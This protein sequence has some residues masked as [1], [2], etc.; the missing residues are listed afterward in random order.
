MG[1]LLKEF[2]GPK[3]AHGCAPRF[4]DSVRSCSSTRAAA[5][6]PVNT[7]GRRPVSAY[8]VSSFCQVIAPLYGGAF[9]VPEAQRPRCFNRFGYAD[10]SNSR[11]S[12]LH[13][14][15]NSGR[16]SDIRK[17]AG[18]VAMSARRSSWGREYRAGTFGPGGRRHGRG[19]GVPC[20]SRDR[21]VSN[22]RRAAGRRADGRRGRRRA[23]H[24]AGPLAVIRLGACER[25]W[26]LAHRPFRP[27]VPAGRPASGRLRAAW[28]RVQQ[29]SGCA[30]CQ[31]SPCGA[32]SHRLPHVL[33]CFF[34]WYRR[35]TRRNA[36]QSSSML[37]KKSVC[38]STRAGR[39]HWQRGGAHTRLVK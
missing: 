6:G 8:P 12:G 19:A 17:D 37:F 4:L 22:R 28:P 29:T 18:L 13:G 2:F 14:R 5:I 32:A 3:A 27:M 33:Q 7:L 9:L 23:R 20:L 25:P 30:T 38:A 34:P 15:E 31:N 24:N 26:R 35:E 11:C 21:P 36:C 10:D 39:H 1:R 16:K